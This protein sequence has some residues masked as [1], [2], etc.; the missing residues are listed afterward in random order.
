MKISGLGHVAVI[1]PDLAA[2]RHFW[3]DCLGLRLECIEDFPAAQA[4]LVVYGAGNDKVELISG[5]APRAGM[6]D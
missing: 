2:S 5:T 1:V 4:R 3:E 6:R